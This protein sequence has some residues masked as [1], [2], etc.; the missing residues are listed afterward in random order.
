[1]GDQIPVI[2]EKPLTTC[3]Y[4]KFQMSLLWIN[5]ARTKDKRYIWVSVWRKTTN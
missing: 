2:V 5:K 4:K 1:M 3:G